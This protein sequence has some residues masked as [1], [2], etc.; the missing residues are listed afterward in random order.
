MK[1]VTYLFVLRHR[2]PWLSQVKKRKT[3]VLWKEMWYFT[4]SQSEG[5]YIIFN[6]PAFL[7]SMKFVTY[8]SVLSHNLKDYTLFP[9]MYFNPCICSKISG[10]TDFIILFSVLCCIRQIGP[11]KTYATLRISS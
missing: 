9:M 1:F 8:L 5:L 2:Q 4:E 7:F 3:E 11:L 6:V 10:F